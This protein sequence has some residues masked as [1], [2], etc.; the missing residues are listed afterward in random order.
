MFRR[1]RD[2]E[3]EIEHGRGVQREALPQRYKMRERIFD[4]GEDFWIENEHGQ[5]AFKVDGK[6]LRLRNTLNIEGPRGEVLCQIQARVARVRDSMAIERNGQKIAEVHK[7]LVNIIHDHFK[8]NMVGRGP[9]LEV[10]GN[11]LDHEYKIE[12]GGRT[13]AE[14]SKKWLRLRD[15]YT[16]DVIPGQDDALMLAITVCVDQLAAGDANRS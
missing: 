2:Q 4:I 10:S 7:D 15:T 6:A 8:V 1:R 11:I 14:V 16:I 5:R 9:D 12:Q 3:P 13:I